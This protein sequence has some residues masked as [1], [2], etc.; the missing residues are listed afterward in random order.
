MTDLTERVNL[1]S[2]TFQL[3][4]TRDVERLEGHLLAGI[5]VAGSVDD[6]HAAACE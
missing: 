5:N 6:P 1:S 4:R 2:E 3:V